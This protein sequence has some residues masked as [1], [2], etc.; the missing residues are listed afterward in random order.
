MTYKEI[1]KLIG[2]SPSALSLVINHKPGVSEATRRK[3][4]AQL[5]ELG[6]DSLIKK[7]QQA[8]AVSSH[9]KIQTF[10]NLCFLIYKK[11]G[12]ILDQHPFFLLLMESIEQ[13]ARK[14]GYNI[15][16][17]TVDQ[18]ILTDDYLQRIKDINAVGV[19]I[20]AT[21]MDDD[22]LLPFL[23]LP[24]PIVAM[25]HN[26]TRINCDTV[27][28]NNFMGTFQAIEYLVNTNH[29]HIGYFKSLTSISS[30]E[31]RNLGYRQAL[32]YY[33]LNFAERDI[34]SV[35]YSEEASYRDV[36]TYLDSCPQLPEAFVCDDDTIAVGALRAFSD[37][38]IIVPRDISIIGFNDR[39]SCQDTIPPLTTINVSRHLLA[40]EAVNT[41]DRLI[42]EKK[43]SQQLGR[44]KKIHIGT[45][46]VVRET[47]KKKPK[48][49]AVDS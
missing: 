47:V 20:F 49:A 3:T 7:E 48:H 26:F 28:I 34:V 32:E 19:I 35:R 46:I 11:N 23:N 33:G 29:K 4:L 14:L 8:V 38:G 21:E 1:A 31:E 22:D 36:C 44:S 25:D 18:R 16:L 39:P 37:H 12:Q 41:L 30:F 10:P 40:I 9:E 43:V 5:K 13:Q 42:Q 15:I 2:I 27:S 17:T 6:L 45:N 24:V